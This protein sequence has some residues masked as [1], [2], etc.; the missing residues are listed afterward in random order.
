MKSASD[1]YGYYNQLKDLLL[2]HDFIVNPYREINYGLQFIVFLGDADGLIRI[3]EG[4]K[5][6]QLDLSQVK[7]PHL[8]HKIESIIVPKKVEETKPLIPKVFDTADAFDNSP[9]T[10]PAE[11]IGIDESGKGDYFGPLVIAAVHTDQKKSLQLKAW[12]VQD[13]KRLSDAKVHSLA[14]KIKS[15][16]FHSL[17]IMGNESYNDVYG[18]IKN[19]NH[20][21]A[22]AHA[23]VLENTLK[24]VPCSYALSDQFGRKSLVENAIRS[25]GIDITIFQRP[26]AESNVAVAAASILARDSF[27]THMKKMSEHYEI[28]FP[29]GA[30]KQTLMTAVKFCKRYSREALPLVAKEH[31]ITS[32]YVDK[33]LKKN[34]PEAS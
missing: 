4:K 17:I 1:K 25:K 20:V 21:L 30:G 24:Q 10:D 33:I 16:C 19:L 31:F 18:K 2:Q 11:L 22:W 34:D 14:P 32:Q 23:K 13:S 8:L 15:L 27:L 26:R 29:K 5:G 6:L 12:G 7:D 28:D 3:Y 9:D